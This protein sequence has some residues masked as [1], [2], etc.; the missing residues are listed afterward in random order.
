MRIV[1]RV[2]SENEDYPNLLLANIHISANI[3]QNLNKMED[4][5]ELAHYKDVNIV[6][7]PELCVTGYIWEA[8]SDIE[9]TQVREHLLSGE[10]K[11]I[12]PWIKNVWDSLK[13]DGKGLEY[14]LFNNV[15]EKNGSLYNAAYVLNK[16]IDYNEEEFIYHKIFLP[17]DEQRYFKGGTDKRLTIDTK[18]GRYGLLICY[19]LN[20]V[21]LARKYAFT[22][23][24]D[25]IITMAAWRSE[26]TREYPEMNV[27][28]DHYY[29]FLWQLMNS[30]KAAY[31]QVWSLGV[32][33]V[34]AH[35]K[36]GVYFWGGSGVWAPSGLQLLQ[37]SNIKD[38]LLIIRNIDI[39][40][41]AHKERDEF[42]YR[43][44]FHSVYRDM[45]EPGKYVGY[46]T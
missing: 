27:K 32:N 33:T 36:S 18:W 45:E 3:Q 19:D 4:I 10:N 34:G 37:A 31:N 43:I 30:S 15:R 46:L 21:E 20:F 5:L 26:A 22:D 6:I 17:K 29:G 41:Q 7:F 38:E 1:E 2:F 12:A 24:V 25:A 44:D 23:E 16:E 13:T 11:R 8:N 40:E 14:V 9:A 42:D 39:K 35:D 28:T